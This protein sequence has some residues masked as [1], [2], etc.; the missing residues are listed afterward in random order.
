MIRNFRH[1]GLK[2]LYE[3]GDRSRVGPDQLETVE[4]ILGFLDI[5]IHPQDL[6]LPGYNLH[7]LK[8]SYKGF[9]S[10]TVSRNWRIIFRIED[11]DAIDVDLIDYH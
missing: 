4:D 9:W 6:D 1:R 2:R 10:V 3:R 8:G 5:A 7:A 11:G